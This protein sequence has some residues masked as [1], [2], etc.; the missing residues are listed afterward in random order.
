MAKLI[1]L[2]A[3]LLFIFQWLHLCLLCGQCDVFLMSCVSH[4]GLARKF[5]SAFCTYTHK[6][7]GLGVDIDA[8]SHTHID[9]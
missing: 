6:K 1:H 8:K 3:I 5:L 7:P 2:H 9:T 4:D